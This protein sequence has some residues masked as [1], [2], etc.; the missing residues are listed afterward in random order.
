MFFYFTPGVNKENDGPGS[1]NEL[2][3]NSMP[4]ISLPIPVKIAVVS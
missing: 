3:A 1:I 2:Y 4:Y